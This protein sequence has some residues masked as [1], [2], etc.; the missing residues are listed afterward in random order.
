MGNEKIQWGLFL[1]VF[2]FGHNIDHCCFYQYNMIIRVAVLKG[3]DWLPG[4]GQVFPFLF[5]LFCCMCL[6]LL[7]MNLSLNILGDCIKQWLNPINI[8]LKEMCFKWLICLFFWKYATKHI[9]LFNDNIVLI[10][11]YQNVF[12]TCIYNTICELP[13][14]LLQLVNTGNTYILY[15]MTPIARSYGQCMTYIHQWHEAGHIWC[16][17]FF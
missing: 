7:N 1:C 17:Y 4:I 14:P 15:T 6:G 13:N 16:M 8:T 11:M 2:Q 5:G 9:L 10:K 3:W 12:T